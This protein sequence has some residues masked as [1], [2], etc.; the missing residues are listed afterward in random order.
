MRAAIYTRVSS[1]GQEENTSLGTQ[2]T[3]CRQYA[4][5]HG[6]NVFAVYQDVHSGFDLWERP[7]ARAMLE[8]IRRR[9]VD[10][11]I[12]YALDRLSRRQ[13]HTAILVDECERAGVELLFVTETFEKTAVGDFLRSAKAFVAELERE[14]IKER[15]QRGLWARIAS[16]K[17][18]GSGFPMFGY[19]WRDEQR[20]AYEIDP[21]TAP[22]VRK[23]FDMAAQ[24]NSTRAI[25]AMLNAEG[26][27]TPRGKERWSHTAVQGILRNDQYTGNARA[28]RFEERTMNG[29]RV[30]RRRP[31]EEHVALPEGTIPPLIAPATFAAVQDR[32]ARNK[33]EATRNNR[34]PGRFLLRAGFVTCGYC[35][36]A[37][38][39][40]LARPY[41]RAPY[42]FYRANDGS[43]HELCGHRFSISA[44]LLDEAVWSRVTALLMQPD[45]IAAEAAKHRDGN[46]TAA[47]LATT[48][49]VLTE[50]A[51][52]QVN[53]ART[54]AAIDDADAAAP[55][56]AEMKALGERKRALEK[57]RAVILAQ[58]EGW[59]ASQEQLDALSTWCRTVA[60]NLGMLSYEEKRLALVALG[61]KVRVWERGHQP[62]YEITVTIPLDRSVKPFVDSVAHC[63]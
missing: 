30:R 63:G 58:F 23:M 2:E 34:E 8:T 31:A 11:I 55:L 24:G 52:K 61:V 3:A 32:L 18:R 29:K 46:P 28:Y 16:G 53:L 47:D 42:A 7:Q 50:V 9:E 10:A 38:S 45:I 54:I 35:G 22:I 1:D 26:I 36:R 21:T 6:Y 33:A 17:L 5:E 49:R 12:A 15:T 37:I 48:D 62:R 19:H 39:A 25:A 51:R 27:L 13:V 44:A 43:S 60:T 41:G 40:R 4:G 59:Q 14:K 57:E 20:D 56:V